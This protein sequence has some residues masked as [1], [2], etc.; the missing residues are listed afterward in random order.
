MDS[1]VP[2]RYFREGSACGGVGVGGR[3]CGPTL[4]P[5]Q[6]A[7]LLHA[8]HSQFSFCSKHYT[9]DDLTHPPVVAYPLLTETS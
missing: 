6:Y 1:D 5:V 3:C 9:G 8:F 2:L 4:I 7:H